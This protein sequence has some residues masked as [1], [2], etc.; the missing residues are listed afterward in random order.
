MFKIPKGNMFAHLGNNERIF[1]DALWWDFKL[2][3]LT[4]LPGPRTRSS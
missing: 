1:C 2:G 3:Q 4:V